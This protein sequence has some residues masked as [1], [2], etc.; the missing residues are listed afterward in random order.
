MPF[1][2]V[3]LLCSLRCACPSGIGEVQVGEDDIIRK[4]S[5]VLY[6]LK[7][8]PLVPWAK[9]IDRHCEYSACTTGRFINDL[10]QRG[11][12]CTSVFGS[13]SVSTPARFASRLFSPNIDLQ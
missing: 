3:E 11:G 6:E 13:C 4:A 12:C 7:L 5:D 9:V 8:A 10:D 2:H 1:Q